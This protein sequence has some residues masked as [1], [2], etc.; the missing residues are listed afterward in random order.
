MRNHPTLAMTL[1]LAKPAAPTSSDCLRQ[2]F[3]LSKLRNSLKNN[4][5]PP[6]FFSVRLRSFRPTQRLDDRFADARRFI[7][8]RMGSGLYGSI[9]AVPYKCL[10]KPTVPRG[11]I[12]KFRFMR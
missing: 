3:I 12:A 2:D 1:P 10:G 7:R 11:R 9:A 4:K 5:L 8:S 6:H